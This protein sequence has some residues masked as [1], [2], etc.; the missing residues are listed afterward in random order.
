MMSATESNPLDAVRADLACPACGYNLRG[1]IGAVVDCP[2]C[3]QACDITQLLTRSWDKPWFHAPNFNRVCLPPAWAALSAVALL[4]LVGPMMAR[5]ATLAI[6][7]IAAGTLAV[8]GLL[9][10]Y[11]WFVFQDL[12]GVWVTAVAHLVIAAVTLGLVG[13]F[14]GFITTGVSV[15]QA[16]WGMALV[17][18]AIL[19]GSVLSLWAGHR[20]ER[21][22][23]RQCIK[24][25][26]DR[27]PTS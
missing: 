19:A 16:E 6:A 26:L 22:I 8:W 24:R 13:C 2:E 3:G 15:L 25:Y 7:M 21:V 17:G 1:L 18:L 4:V 27:R 23:A 9:W 14:V 12:R 10:V 20:G 11:A 5:R